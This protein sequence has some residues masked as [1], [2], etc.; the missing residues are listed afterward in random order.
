MAM[1]PEGARQ[2]LQGGPGSGGSGG[3]D[4]AW[5]GSLPKKVPG[6]RNLL[7]LHMTSCR[8]AA[9][10][11]EQITTSKHKHGLRHHVYPRGNEGIVAAV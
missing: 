5:T 7:R 8:A 4:P 11:Y 10:H 9:N 3:L 2:L 1:Q 6:C